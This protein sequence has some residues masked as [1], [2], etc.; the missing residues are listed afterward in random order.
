MKRS[1]FIKLTVAGAAAVALPL[2]YGCGGN[3]AKKLIAEPEF[4]LKLIDVKTLYETGQA[5][6]KKFPVE[7][8][9]K[10]LTDLLVENSA[11]VQSS[12]TKAIHLFFDKKI[13]DDFESGNTVIVNGWILSLTEA[14][15]CALFSITQ[16]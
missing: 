15:Q 16:N 10:K 6:I 8:N 14:R 12:D 4:L 13:H 2:T 11:I 1:V 3:S 9:E 5:Y 7:D